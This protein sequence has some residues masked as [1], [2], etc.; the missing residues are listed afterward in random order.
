MVTCIAMWQWLGW[1]QKF[2]CGIVHQR[3]IRKLQV[4]EF[5]VLCQRYFM[6]N[7][8]LFIGVKVNHFIRFVRMKTGMGRS[9]D[10]WM[11]SFGLLQNR[12]DVYI[13][14]NIRS[15]SHLIIFANPSCRFVLVVDWCHIEEISKNSKIS[16]PE[17][18]I[19]RCFKIHSDMW[20]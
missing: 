18:N 20:K 10:Q 15:S 12:L 7:W 8:F 19:N 14:S 16:I 13:S 5:A 9:M 1:W 6:I 4:F 3:H 11:T 17:H 2:A